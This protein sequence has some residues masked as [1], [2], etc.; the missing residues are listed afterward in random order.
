MFVVFPDIR[1]YLQVNNIIFLNKVNIL[2]VIYMDIPS[3]MTI[4]RYAKIFSIVSKSNFYGLFGM[5]LPGAET[6]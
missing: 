3:L 6:V 4:N 1:I 2:F 5:M